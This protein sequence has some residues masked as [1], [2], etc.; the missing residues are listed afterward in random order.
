[1]N[2]LQAIILSIVEGIT[3]FL[4]I[5]S[6]GHLI[7]A[8]RLLGVP[9]SEFLKTFEISIQLG[10]IV[11]VLLLYGK[12]LVQ[13]KAVFYRVLWVFVPTGFLGFLLYKVIKRYLLGNI[14]VTVSALFIGGIIILLIER[15]LK[16]QEKT[17]SIKQFNFRNSIILGVLQTL[18]VIPGVSRSATTIFGGMFLGL[19]R[20]A[21]T[22]L[23][24][25]VALP[26]LLAATTLD[27]FKTAWS[28]SSYEL[29]L[30]A[31]GMVLSCITSLLVMKWLVHF[32]KK[33]SF[34]GFGIY[35]IAIALVF[36]LF[37]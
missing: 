24:F 34:A 33:N 10:A 17:G 12:K 11:S 29:S 9:P 21:A 4:P 27:L 3:E 30:I 6:T 22:E 20:E 32:V 8:S 5:S 15:N 35:R 36:L 19:S 31:L 13:E 18:S 16:S 7:L 23:S 26:V 1:M 37:I 14:I 2:I 28:F 25:L